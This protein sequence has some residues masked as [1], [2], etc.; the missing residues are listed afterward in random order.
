MEVVAVRAGI[1]A[2]T[3][4]ADSLQICFG[5]SQADIPGKGEMLLQYGPG[6][7]AVLIVSVSCAMVTVHVLKQFI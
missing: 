2:E 6:I 3:H 1:A 7:G 5:V 4:G